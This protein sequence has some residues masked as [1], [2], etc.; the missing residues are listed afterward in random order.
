MKHNWN[1]NDESL[2][3]L[4]TLESKTLI[5]HKKEKKFSRNVYFGL[6]LNKII[7]QRVT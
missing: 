6:F 2:D 3:C 5:K 7:P 1:S 4:Y